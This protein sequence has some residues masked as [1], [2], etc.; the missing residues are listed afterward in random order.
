MTKTIQTTKSKE[1][2]CQ[3]VKIVSAAKN[4][5]HE[6][7]AKEE[8]VK[9]NENGEESYCALGAME[10]A[11][12]DDIGS[13]SEIS[14]TLFK[15]PYLFDAFKTVFRKEFKK[16]RKDDSNEDDNDKVVL[17]EAI[18]TFNDDEDTSKRMLTGRFKRVLTHLEKNAPKSRSK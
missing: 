3:A 2:F 7:W 6:G 18:F 15:N 10:K 1:S 8:L 4:Y 16:A 11:F 17:G 14:K 13:E 9:E 5:L 12:G